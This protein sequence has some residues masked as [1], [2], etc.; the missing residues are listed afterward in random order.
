[1]PLFEPENVNLDTYTHGWSEVDFVLVHNLE[2][3]IM[4]RFSSIC[5]PEAKFQQFLAHVIPTSLFY[6]RA[7]SVRRAEHDHLSCGHPSI[8]LQASFLCVESL[9][10]KVRSDILRIGSPSPISISISSF[11]HNSLTTKP[12]L[13]QC[14]LH[15]WAES[16]GL[17]SPSCS[18]YNPVFL[19]KHDVSPAVYERTG[20][21]PPVT[22]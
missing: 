22:S 10:E 15:M 2:G 7:I 13:R 5:F 17:M 9:A 14:V 16:Q 19:P 11:L 1:M 20:C 8:L 3:N 6:I 21:T 12:G 18:S 4:T